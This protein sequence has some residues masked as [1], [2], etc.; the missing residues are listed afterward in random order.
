MSRFVP[1]SILKYGAEKKKKRL[2]THSTAPDER[3]ALSFRCT[4]IKFSSLCIFRSQN[5]LGHRRSKTPNIVKIQKTAKVPAR[6]QAARGRGEAPRR[7]RG[8]AS[9]A[10]ARAAPLY[11]TPPTAPRAR[12]PAPAPS[13]HARRRYYFELLFRSSFNWFFLGNPALQS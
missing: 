13:T 9:A 8:Q 6:G 11:T 1:S 7:G 3:R 12:R 5:R 2:S 4:R 10:R